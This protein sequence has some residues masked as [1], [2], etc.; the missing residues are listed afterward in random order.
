MI[1]SYGK[2]IVVYGD[3]HVG[4]TT[5][6]NEIYDWLISNGASVVSKKKQVGG[7]KNDFEEMLPYE[8]KNVAFLS[9]G[10]LIRL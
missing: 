3:S 4:K 8:R 5:V 2:I 1:F 7:N 9:M 10:E 6:I